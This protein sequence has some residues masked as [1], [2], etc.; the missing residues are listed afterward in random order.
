MSPLLPESPETRHPT[1]I[2][3]CGLRSTEAA[4]AASNAGADYLGF[5][6]VEGVRRQIQPDEAA[7][8]ITDYR[9]QRNDR[10]Q[11]G[12]VGLFL[13]QDPDFVNETSH[14]LG[15]DYLQLCGDEDVDYFSKV[16]LPIF[17][18]VRVKDG[19][20]PADLDQMIAPLLDAGHSVLLDRYDK[21]T[22]GG[23]GKTF[24]WSIAQGIASRNNVLLAGG[25]NPE[26]VQSA[27][28]QLSPWAVD[29]SS[30]VET[31]GT[32]DPDRIRAFIEA[33]QA[34]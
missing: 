33:A 4:L 15:L 29:V 28:T 24:D 2:K 6:F 34:V 9:A 26:N 11:P 10:Y 32:K 17:K 16:E 18:M 20:T 21:G 30:G 27:S 1:R 3:I 13:D 14:R 23:S 5:N 8:I 22:P 25:L 7:R 12:L 19:T 31:D